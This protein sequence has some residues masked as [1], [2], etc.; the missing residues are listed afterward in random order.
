MNA[1]L[2]FLQLWKCVLGKSLKN[3]DLF[4]LLLCICTLIS[5]FLTP[6]LQP[7]ILS[8]AFFS[9]KF[10]LTT[11]LRTLH[12]AKRIKNISI[13]MLFLMLLNTFVFTYL[14]N[15]Y[16]STKLFY[17]SFGK[18]W[19]TM[20]EVLTLDVEFLLIRVLGLA[21]SNPR[22]RSR[23]L[24]PPFHHDQPLRFPDQLLLH[25]HLDW[26]HPRVA[27]VGKRG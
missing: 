11:I 27:L 23:L 17:G 13:T 4:D 16:E 15:Q 24:G 12:L 8:L 2:L 21:R 7:A 25:E 22:A 1:S 6:Q 9:F 3:I 14:Y 10:N 18:T 19:F 20:L 5:R 26:L